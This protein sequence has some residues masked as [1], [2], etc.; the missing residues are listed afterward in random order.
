M[1][2]MLISSPHAFAMQK[3]WELETRLVQYQ[4][5]AIPWM[6][7]YKVTMYHWD[8]VQCICHFMNTDMLIYIIKKQKVPCCMVLCSAH[9]HLPERLGSG[10]QSS[11]I[12]VATCV[13]KSHYVGQ[14]YVHER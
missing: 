4:V 2:L 3:G 12:P 13:V 11:L 10:D 7:D 14:V 1:W 9:M 8:Q 6:C 5:V